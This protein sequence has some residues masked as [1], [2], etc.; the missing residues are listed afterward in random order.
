MSQLQQNLKNPSCKHIQQGG[1]AYQ[2][3]EHISEESFTYQQQMLYLDKWCILR[4]MFYKP[5]IESEDLEFTD[6]K[7]T[8]FT[9]IALQIVDES[10]TD[11]VSV[12]KL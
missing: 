5:L 2:S 11:I 12:V 10:E 7:Y 8:L 4:Y 1:S 6:L 9:N 3:W